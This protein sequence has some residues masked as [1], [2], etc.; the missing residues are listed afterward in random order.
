M[1]QLK[2]AIP[3]AANGRQILSAAQVCALIGVSRPTLSRACK[4]GRISFYQIGRRVLFDLDLHVQP[5]LKACEVRAS[6]ERKD[7]A[8]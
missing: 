2:H 6:E 1:R 4:A 3:V 8:A 7:K 5:Y